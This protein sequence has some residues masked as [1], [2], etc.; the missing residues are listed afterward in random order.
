M[1]IRITK[2][3][4][5]AFLLALCMT[6]AMFAQTAG[7]VTA[8]RNSGLLK[9]PPLKVG[10]YPVGKVSKTV[11]WVALTNYLFKQFKAH[12]TEINISKFK[13]PVD[14]TN[15]KHLASIV[16]GTPKYLRM[17]SMFSH[18]KDDTGKVFKCIFPTYRYSK[19]GCDK[20][21]EYCD[22]AVSKITA[23]LK[24]NTYLSEAEK[25]LLV[26]DRLACLSEYDY[27]NYLDEK[28]GLIDELPDEDYNA[29]GPLVLGAG[30]CTGYTA[31]MSLCL[32][33]LGIKSYSVDSDD[34]NHSWNIVYLDGTPYFVDTTWDDSTWD[35]CGRSK[36]ENL[37]VSTSKLKGNHKA[38]DYPTDPVSTYYDN[39]YWTCSDTAFQLID[40]NLYY[41]DN[42][43]ETLCR[44]NSNGTSTVLKDLDY[45]WY[46]DSNGRYWTNNYSKLAS[47][48]G[49][50]IYSTPTEVC[51]YNVS[52]G[53]TMVL[54][55][56]HLNTSDCYYIY[57]MTVKDCMLY[58][59]VN[60]SPK[61][62]RDTKAKYQIRVE[63]PHVK[64]H[65]TE[66]KKVYCTDTGY[67]EGTY[68]TVC[69]KVFSGMK[70]T[71]PAT[72]HTWGQKVLAEK[73]TPNKDGKY[74]TSCA[75]CP[76][77]KETTI[78]KVS[79][80]R[81]SKASYVYD[82]KVKTPSVTVRDSQGNELS[83][84]NYTITRSNK[85]SKETGVYKV[86]V[87]LSGN[88]S[89]KKVL[90]Y[91][92][93][94][95][96]VKNLKQTKVT[97]TTVTMK[98]NSVKGAIYYKIQFSQD[99]GKTWIDTGVVSQTSVTMTSMTPGTKY[100]FRIVAMDGD[101]KV[102]GKASAVLKTQTLCSAPKITVLESTKPGIV[103]V[104]WDE[105]SGA[106]EY[107]IF[108]SADSKNWERIGTVDYTD[109]EITGFD[110]DEKAYIMV[111][112][113]NA[114]GK[115]G[116]RSAVKSVIIQK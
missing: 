2:V 22:N 38:N 96:K 58:I 35:I 78:P 113:I 93:T 4:V 40:N 107:L 81:L 88:Y 110:N 51:S 70:K 75:N 10:T 63:L 42:R 112:A 9:N 44:R 43:E 37:L 28:K 27:A 74:V 67:A 24:A 60:N 82:G 3:Q 98:W 100:R 114:Y 108:W 31:A 11:D 73:A 5:T 66:K 7:A 33:S 59:D 84:K 71:I 77:K 29:Y 95:A 16:Y 50:L 86:T 90:K 49:N 109:V 62:E 111:R 41:I 69:G 79:G 15:R 99:D 48:A 21:R 30:V 89:G 52:T 13:V 101:M 53:E 83:S 23:G 103:H 32:E 105:V 1:R 8:E 94:P 80:I 36:H 55:S 39:Y 14:E 106:K 25:V 57:G 72:K 102:S 65:V 18:S 45:T 91:K 19:A 12:E 34:M 17:V 20:M 85:A 76:A 26:H 56:P 87:K 68:C 104:K 54:Y 46:A 115:S 64:K 6:F 116:K 61:F 92:I 47:Y 97:T